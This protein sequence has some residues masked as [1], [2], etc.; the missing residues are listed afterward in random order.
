MASF[1]GTFEE[2]IKYINPRVK[3]VVNGIS[4]AYK[5]EVGMCEHCSSVEVTLEAA[6]VTGR[7]RLVIIE[8]V[9]QDYVNGEIVTVDLGVF[10]NRFIR[11]HDPISDVIKV[12]C[13]P[14]HRQYDNQAQPVP[15]QEAIQGAAETEVCVVEPVT[16]TNA[17]ITDFLRKAVPQLPE[18]EI[19]K[20]LDAEL[21]KRKFDVNFSVLK[22]VPLGSDTETILRYAQVN[23]YNRWST[24]QPILVGNRKFLVL[25]QWYE[26]NRGPFLRWKEEVEYQLG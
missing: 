18:T 4:R 5:Q 12:L 24:R 10:E 16:I 23:G 17:E 7:E 20:L 15:E 6:H 22:E 26:R 2:F 1:I 11:A 9:L 19:E 21:C 8:E 13:R 25:T 3:N 14:C